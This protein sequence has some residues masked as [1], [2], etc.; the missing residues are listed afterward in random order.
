MGIL[1]VDEF[2]QKLVNCT[3][4]QQKESICQQ[5]KEYIDR[6]YSSIAS[7]KSAYSK[8]R[9]SV[10]EFYFKDKYPGK[11]IFKAVLEIKLDREKTAS[12]LKLYMQVAS[13]YN[14]GMTILKDSTEFYQLI[15][16][17]LRL[18]QYESDSLA[19]DYK[20]KIVKQ[21]TK[22]KNILNVDG[23][24]ERAVEL[25]EAKSYIARILAIAALTGR[26]VAEIGCSATF[27]YKTNNSVLFTGQLKLK[28]NDCPPYIIP[29]LAN[30]KSIITCLKGLRVDKPQYLNNPG[31]FHSSCSKDL[32]IAVKKYFSEFV[33]G[34]ITAKDLRAIYATIASAKF[35]NIS[36]KHHL[37]DNIY[38]AEI[39][40]HQDGDITT[41]LSYQSYQIKADYH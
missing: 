19:K 8:Y 28:T 34:V 21:Q 38:F 25:L 17:S 11:N 20:I 39:L 16:H 33:E 26:K 32:S 9:M 15:C 30:A 22:P 12:K 18:K 4:E 31:N 2:Y 41:Q 3:T 1:R 23:F 29:V 35:N 24:I 5:E 6:N 37:K 7:R 27:S 40:G 13:K 10:D 36:S 14:L